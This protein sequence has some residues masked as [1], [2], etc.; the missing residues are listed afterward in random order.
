MRPDD[1]RVEIYS[2]VE[3]GQLGLG[4]RMNGPATVQDL[5]DAWQPLCDDPTIYKSYAEGNYAACRGCQLNCCPT[6]YV[7]PD[8]VSFKRM[9]ASLELD[10]A[11]FID[12]YCQKEKLEVGLLRLQPNPCTFLSDNICTVYP[13]RSLI[14]RLYLCTRLLG[15]TEEL[16]YKIAWTGAAATQIFAER[17]SLLPSKA[18]AASSFDRLFI[19]LVEE[20]RQHLGVKSFLQARDYSD[21]PLYHFLPLKNAR[22]RSEDFPG[23][24]TARPVPPDLE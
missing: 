23:A 13:V 15:E 18:G 22:N 19:N 12:R 8:L 17:N 20:Y 4:V 10:H 24:E 3:N 21:I 9:A 11:E 1:Q 14:C 16:I 2:A 6:A 7:I 5:L